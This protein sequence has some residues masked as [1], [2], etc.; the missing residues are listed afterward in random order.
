[1]DCHFRFDEAETPTRVGDDDDDSNDTEDAELV[2]SSKRLAL[3]PVSVVKAR[4][5]AN[6]LIRP[7][8]GLLFYNQYAPA[9]LPPSSAPLSQG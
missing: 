1:L 5:I 7:G 9:P 4:S 2:D 6:M 3:V 8:T